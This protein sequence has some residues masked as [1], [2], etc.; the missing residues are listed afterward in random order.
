MK[1]LTSWC[2]AEV[3]FK[4][5]RN[6]I[7]LDFLFQYEYWLFHFER[8]TFSLSSLNTMYFQIAN[9]SQNNVYSCYEGKPCTFERLL[10]FKIIQWVWIQLEKMKPSSL[11]WNCFWVFILTEELD[12]GYMIRCRSTYF[13]R[14]LL[15][16]L[17][18]VLICEYEVKND[19][20]MRATWFEV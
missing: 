11:N 6:Q 4:C 3:L 16:L 14:R 19:N 8:P 12:T 20:V 5:S 10:K 17:S 13:R 7:R 1:T 9:R 15:V 2:T 18:K